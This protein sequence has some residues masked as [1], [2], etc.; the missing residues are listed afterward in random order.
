MRNRSITTF[1]LQ[2]SPSHLL[3]LY[4]ERRSAPHMIL[5][6]RTFRTT[7]VRKNPPLG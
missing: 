3:F 7:T 4:R 2:L 6:N 1:A 5:V